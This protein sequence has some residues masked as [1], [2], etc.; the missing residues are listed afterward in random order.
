MKR[1]K[2]PFKRKSK[3]KTRKIGASTSTQE[4]H[5]P[6]DS[7]ALSKSSLSEAPFPFGSKQ[8]SFSLPQQ[9]PTYTPS[10]STIS[11]PTPSKPHNSETNTSSPPLQNFDLT[12]TTLPVSE[13]LLLN[14]T[15]SPP[16]S[17]PSSPSYHDLSSDVDH[18]EIHDPSSPTLAQLQDTTNSKQTSSVPETSV[19]TPFLYAPPSAPS[20]IKEIEEKFADEATAT[21][22]KA[23]VKVD[24]EEATRIAAEE[25][26][27]STEVALTR[28]ESSTSD[29]ASLVLH[30]LEE[31]QKE[32]QLI[33]SRLDKQ[34]SVISNI[35]NLLTQLLHRMSPPPNP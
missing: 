1:M 33:R 8:I 19:P 13:A 5:A 6:L 25:A 30:T 2:E 18:P 35:Q 4:L 9:P 23:K 12:T 17:T 10:E 3:K 34:D 27:K 21:E 29:I 14:E 15:I 31:L 28:G 22:A 26:A 16:S 20:A 32:Q 7:S 24:A 11:I